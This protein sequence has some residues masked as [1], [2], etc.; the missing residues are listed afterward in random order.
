[1]FGIIQIARLLFL[2]ILSFFVALALTKPL[3]YFLK[4]FNLI[5][6]LR[7]IDINEINPELDVNGQTVKL[8][9]KILGEVLGN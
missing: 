8:G 3:I 7:V 5:K 6:S 1:M 2:A 9:T 4:R